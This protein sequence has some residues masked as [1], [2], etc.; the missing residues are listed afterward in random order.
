M[1]I[2]CIRLTGLYGFN[3]FKI[4]EGQNGANMQ[5]VIFVSTIIMAL[6]IEVQYKGQCRI[7]HDTPTASHQEL[8]LA[9][10]CLQIFIVLQTKSHYNRTYKYYILH[11]G[12]ILTL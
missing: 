7:Q 9:P 3:Q 4:L 2:L 11:V 8:P 12:T 5:D 10:I 1:F 6:R